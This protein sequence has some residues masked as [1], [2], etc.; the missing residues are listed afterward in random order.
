MQ[1]KNRFMRA[2]TPYLQLYAIFISYP[3]SRPLIVKENLYLR[4]TVQ[5]EM[6]PVDWISVSKVNWVAW[7]MQCSS[8]AVHFAIWLMTLWDK[9]TGPAAQGLTGSF[10]LC[11]KAVTTVDSIHTGQKKNRTPDSLKIVN[12]DKLLIF[13]KIL[14]VYVFWQDLGLKKTECF[15]FS[16]QI[17]SFKQSMTICTGSPFTPGRPLSLPR[18]RQVLFMHSLRCPYNEFSLPMETCAVTWKS[19]YVLIGTHT[20]I[21]IIFL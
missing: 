13:K 1:K 10:L 14:K 8:F 17:K 9:G 4:A 18:M 20:L 6:V 21:Q 2:S 19:I 12:W 11:F 7:M 16:Y 3:S 5:W 15:T